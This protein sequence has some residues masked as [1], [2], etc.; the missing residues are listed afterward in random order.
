MFIGIGLILAFRKKDGKGIGMRWDG[1]ERG[2][3]GIEREGKWKGWKGMR[4]DEKGKRKSGNWM[5]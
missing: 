2:W 1:N 3:D 5:N 4:R